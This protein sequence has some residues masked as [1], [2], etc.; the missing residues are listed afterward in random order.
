MITVGQLVFSGILI[1]SVYA[2]MS[3]G[4]TL[5]FGVLRLHLALVLL[6]LHLGLIELLRV[7]PHNLAFVLKNHLIGRRVLAKSRRGT[8]DCGCDG[9]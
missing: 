4:L 6:L 8:D 7:L 1:G 9:H 3:I 5:I 2:L